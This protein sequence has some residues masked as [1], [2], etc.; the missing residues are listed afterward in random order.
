[1]ITPTNLIT[2]DASSPDPCPYKLGDSGL[3]SVLDIVITNGSFPGSSVLKAA[4]KIIQ[5][6]FQNLEKQCVEGALRKI[7]GSVKK[8]GREETTFPLVGQYLDLSIQDPST[9]PPCIDIGQRRE[10]SDWWKGP[11]L[12]IRLQK[13]SRVLWSIGHGKPP[14]IFNRGPKVN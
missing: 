1:M 9:R 2:P 10:S 6:S 7:I 12:S 14:L 5:E 11:A 13:A 4:S 3:M 8:G